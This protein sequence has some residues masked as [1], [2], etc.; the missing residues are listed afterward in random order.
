L[1]NALP[2]KPPSVSLV[3]LTERE[4][5][6]VQKASLSTTL[7]ELIGLRDELLGENPVG[8]GRLVGDLLGFGVPRDL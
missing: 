5:G 6:Y 1:F 7:D 2:I 4:R 8:E 3:R